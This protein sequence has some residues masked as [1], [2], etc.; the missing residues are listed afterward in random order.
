[1]WKKST[2]GTF[3]DNKG[4]VQQTISIAEAWRRKNLKKSISGRDFLDINTVTASL[5]CAICSMGTRG[6]RGVTV[7]NSTFIS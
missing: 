3:D 5:M 4:G 2:Q 1:V 6:R 7:G